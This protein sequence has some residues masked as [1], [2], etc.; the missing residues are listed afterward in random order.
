MFSIIIPTFNNIKYLKLC[1][2]SISKNSKYNH[3]IIIHINEGVDGTL[4]FVKKNGFLYT[5]SK[6]NQGVCIA[7][8]KGVDQSN[9]KFIVLAH[10]D[11]YFCPGWDECF[12]VQLDKIEN[13][14]FFLSGTMVQPFDSYINL[15]CGRNIEEF[16]EVKLLKELPSKLHYAKICPLQY[17]IW[18]RYARSYLQLSFILEISTNKEYSSPINIPK[19]V[20]NAENIRFCTAA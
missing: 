9:K 7:F 4:D 16:D 19:E 14:N 6:Y 10:D 20:C 13:N 15:N 8:N 2:E 11:M 12:K 3:E 18:S 5:Y 1:L 17:R